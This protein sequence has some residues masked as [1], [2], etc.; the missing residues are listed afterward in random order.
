MSIFQRNDVAGMA[1]EMVHVSLPRTW[2]GDGTKMC[3]ILAEGYPNGYEVNYNANQYANTIKAINDAGFAVINSQFGTNAFGNSTAQQR[4]TS[5]LA[6]MR[7]VHGA[8]ATKVALVGFS[9]GAMNVLAWAGNNKAQVAYIHTWCPA[10]DQAYANSNSDFTGPLNAAY[11]GWS[12][13]T[14]GATCNPKTMASAG[15]YNGIPIRLEYAGDDL[16]IPP[17]LVTVFEG[18]VTTATAVNVGQGGHSMVHCSKPETLNILT[19][20][21]KEVN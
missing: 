14:Y 2:K 20:K 12:E 19:N 4:I 1:G 21:L 6:Y 16:V 3:V 13:A 7:T 11:G 9:M 8:H 10:T 17:S 5:A 15:K 18:A